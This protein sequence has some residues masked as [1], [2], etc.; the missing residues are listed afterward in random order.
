D[1]PLA[2]DL[3]VVDEASML[4]ALLANQ[5][6]KAIP[7]GAHLLLV[8]DPDQLPSVGAGDVLADLLRS[9]RFPVTRLE[10][11]F[12]QGAG[13]GIALN[14]RRV[15]AGEMPR[16]GGDVTDCYF[17]TAEEPAAAANTVVD[18][19]AE[20]LPRRYGFGPGQVQ[21]L[22]PMHRGAAGVGA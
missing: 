8:G 5:L 20:R 9:G 16:F 18:L 22:S 12:R 7:P 10:H 19:V 17:L 13:S 2:A 14:A 3:V 11:V 6:V 4:D 1:A 21:L 15:N